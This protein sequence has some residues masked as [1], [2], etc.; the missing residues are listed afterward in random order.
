MTDT[1]PKPRIKI[2]SAKAKGRKAQQMVRDWLLKLFPDLEPDDV[3]S[4]SM[5]AG[6]ADIQLS[7]AARKVIQYAW[8]VKACAKAT[9]QTNFDQ[10]SRHA[11][12]SPSKAHPIVVTKVDRK[13]ALATIELSHL[14]ELWRLAGIVR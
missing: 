8:E 5:G 3:V 9:I 13:P 7:P 6:G 10:A 12:K 1:L 11:A 14:E 2:S 4:T